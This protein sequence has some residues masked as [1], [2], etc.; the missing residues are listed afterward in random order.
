[1]DEKSADELDGRISQPGGASRTRATEN[2]GSK[3]L[4]LMIA[5]ASVRLADQMEERV[6]AKV[7]PLKQ[8]GHSTATGA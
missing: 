6:Q 2:Q 4:F 3:A 1:L 7:L 8:D 5:G